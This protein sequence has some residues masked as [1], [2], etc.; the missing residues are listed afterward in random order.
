VWRNQIYRL[1]SGGMMVAPD[2]TLER[3]PV[4]TA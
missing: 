1:T 2:E 4:L 3:E